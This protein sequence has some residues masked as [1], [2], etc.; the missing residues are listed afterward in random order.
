MK[1]TRHKRKHH[2]ILLMTSDAVEEQVR[3]YRLSPKFLYLAEI[4]LCL[5]V[6]ALIG[7]CFYEGEITKEKMDEVSAK[8]EEISQLS[9]TNAELE[10]QI[11]SLNETVQILSDTVNQKTQSET[12]LSEQLEKQTT[13]SQFP[14]DSSASIE[15]ATEGDPML[16][17]TA[18][19]GSMVVATANGTVTAVNEDAEYGNN[20]WIDHGNGYVTIYRNKGE[21]KV[22]QGETVTQGTTLFVIDEDNSQLGYQI[23]LD[24]AYIDPMDVLVI[25]G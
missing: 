24:G 8:E 5:T 12:E 4:V 17:F 18:T 22:K 2:T 11:A 23:M 14:L 1:R 10:A 9:A 3:Q 16:V 7:V 21:A 19:T 25:N 20:I 6:G 13:P 15:E